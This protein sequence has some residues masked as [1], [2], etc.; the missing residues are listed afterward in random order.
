VCGITGYTGHLD[1]AP[2]IVNS[3]SRVE[4]R[5]YDS[6][7]MA[8]R[9]EAGIQITKDIISVEHLGNQS[10]VFK[11]TTGIGHTRWATVGSPSISNAHPHIDCNSKIAIVH[12]GDIDNYHLLK[13]ELTLKGHFFQ[14]DTDSEVLAHL[15][16]EE[17]VSDPVTRIIGAL[18]RVQGSYA[19]VVLHKQ[20]NALVVAR[21]EN[22][23]VVGIGQGEN[24][25]ASDVPGVLEKTA[26]IVYL[27]DGDIGVVLPDSFKVWHQEVPTERKIHQVTWE[28]KDL[29]KGEFA[30]YTLKEIFEQPQAIRQT[31]AGRLNQTGGLIRSEITSFRNRCPETIQLVSC[32]TGYHACLIAQHFLSS[33][34]Q[35]KVSSLLAS[36]AE[37]APVKGKNAWSIFLTQSGETADTIAAA[38]LARRAGYFTLALTNSRDSSIT[39]TVDETLYTV[40]G[41]ELSVAATKTFIALLIGLYLLGLEL[42]DP[43]AEVAHQLLSELQQL[44]EKVD[45]ILQEH[46]KIKRISKFISAHQSIFLI[47]KGINFPVALEGAL[48]LKELAY[49]H[50]EGYP[51]GELKHGSFALLGHDTPVIA[52]APQDGTYNRM[53]NTIKEIKARN[54]PVVVITNG[55]EG[56]ITQIA[57]E[58]IMLPNTDPLLSPALSAVALQLLAY[59]CAIERG[60]PIDRPRNLAKSVTVH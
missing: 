33:I 30:H 21:R 6:C 54:A 22:P 42:C 26:Q 14:S 28:L 24:L 7:G 25:V 41:L 51:A 43:P 38:R 36:E 9:T 55:T 8:I 15:I 35:I 3:L 50:A 58:V 59:Y 11:G 20:S 47:G 17:Q 19:L 49:I 56:E 46:S 27:E 29:D 5:G 18:R 1:A 31:L 2:I 45:L 37:F 16:E 39:R 32:G 60:C 23:L 40:A 13:E 57:D 53:L 44:P 12:N 10:P 34:S 52:I 4:Y 48:K